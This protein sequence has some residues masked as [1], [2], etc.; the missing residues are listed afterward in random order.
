MARE[1][2][3]ARDGELSV[4]EDQGAGRV[5]VEP[6][7]RPVPPHLVFTSLRSPS[8]ARVSRADAEILFEALGRWLGVRP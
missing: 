8:P 2:F 4:A 6:G 1:I 7:Y 5:V 3:A